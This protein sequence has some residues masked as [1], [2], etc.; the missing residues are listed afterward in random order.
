MNT[1]S[2]NGF[3]FDTQVSDALD[4]LR[5]NHVDA[6]VKIRQEFSETLVWDGSWLDCE[7]MGVDPDWPSWLVD[8]IEN[9]GLVEWIDG[10]PYSVSDS[11]GVR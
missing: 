5:I 7:A 4:Y 2:S 9:T 10:E 6:Y 11:A 3:S 8:A 1:I